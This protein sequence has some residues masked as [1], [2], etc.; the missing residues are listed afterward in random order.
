MSLA[1]F[2]G[3]ESCNTREQI[4]RVHEV[5]PMSEKK[6]KKE[7]KG[8][9]H[10]KVS[11]EIIVILGTHFSLNILWTCMIKQFKLMKVPKKFEVQIL[12]HV[13][14]HSSQHVCPQIGVA[15][16]F[17]SCLLSIFD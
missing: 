12:V 5:A 4:G 7:K 16:N 17:D 2:I 6:K 9:M 15:T 13:L 3:L 8:N 11:L 14:T 10:R 1:I